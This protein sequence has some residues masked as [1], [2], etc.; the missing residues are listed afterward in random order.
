[1]KDREY[2]TKCHRITGNQYAGHAIL[3]EGCEVCGLDRKQNGYS[4][5][6]VLYIREKSLQNVWWLFRPIARLFYSNGKKS[7]PEV[8]LDCKIADENRR[9]QRQFDR[10]S[11]K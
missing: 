6:D 9:W 11:R 10:L 3:Y 5:K 7:I 1:M 2:C 4:L 8:E